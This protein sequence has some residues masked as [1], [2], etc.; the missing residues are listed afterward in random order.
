[1]HTQRVDRFL[2]D[3]PRR[4]RDHANAGG[5]T[6]GNPTDAISWTGL[7]R[8]SQTGPSA[9]ELERNHPHPSRAGALGRKV[10]RPHADAPLASAQ[11]IRVRAAASVNMIVDVWRIYA[12]AFGAKHFPPSDWL[13]LRR[14]SAW[15]ATAHLMGVPA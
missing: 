12:G 9:A 4:T 8:L 11:G 15:I 3:P 14:G 10:T 7:S 2:H 1:M 5:P 6:W 13:A